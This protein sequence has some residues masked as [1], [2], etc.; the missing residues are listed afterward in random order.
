MRYEFELIGSTAILMHNDDV[1]WA[2]KVSEWLLDPEN[3]KK[4]GEKSGDDRRPAWAWTGYCYHDGENLAMP[5]ACLTS[6]FK[7][8][9]A[10]V[11]LS[12][13]KTFKEL[14][15]SGI[16]FEKE[17]LE[18]RNNDKQIPVAL[19]HDLLDETEFRKHAEMAEKLGFKLFVKRAAIGTAKHVRVRPR[20]DK[21]TVRGELEVTAHEISAE[22]LKNIFTQAG[23]VGLGDWRPGAPKSPGPYGMFEAK[24]KPIK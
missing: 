3:T 8:A 22:V 24:V 18:F 20:F 19:I 23:R 17:H 15:V 1:E 5:S 9:G 12:G 10:R 4:K 16:F 14:A 21:W 13:K 2:D 7:K 6:C 11:P